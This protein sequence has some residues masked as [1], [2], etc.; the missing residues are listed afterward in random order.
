MAFNMALILWP[1]NLSYDWQLGSIPLI[2]S[3]RDPRNLL[4]LSLALAIILLSYKCRSLIWDVVRYLIASVNA[5]PLVMPAPA[6][7]PSNPLAD[8]R[9]EVRPLVTVSL[10]MVRLM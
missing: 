5:N 9:H 10:C 4:S 1:E 3:V 2:T 7:S 8:Q 6:A